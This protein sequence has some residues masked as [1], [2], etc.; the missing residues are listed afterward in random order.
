MNSLKRWNDNGS[1][2]GK[3][4]KNS[5]NGVGSATFRQFEKMNQNKDFEIS[6]MGLSKFKGFTPRAPAKF[7]LN[8]AQSNPDSRASS[9]KITAN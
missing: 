9:P 8:N 2:I 6:P 3:N 4:S 7:G 5:E 1:S